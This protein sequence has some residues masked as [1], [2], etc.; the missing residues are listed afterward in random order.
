MVKVFRYHSIGP[1]QLFGKQPKLTDTCSIA[2]KSIGLLRT[3]SYKQNFSIHY[4]GFCF[5]EILSKD[6]LVKNFGLD[7]FQRKL[8]QKS[9]IGLGRSVINDKGS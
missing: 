9:F 1:Y 2:R 4:A 3:H 6:F 7:I 8:C 5:A